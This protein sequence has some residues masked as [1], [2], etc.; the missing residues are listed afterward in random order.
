V[1]RYIFPDEVQRVSPL[2]SL[3]HFERFLLVPPLR[4]AM[5]GT[6]WTEKIQKI[7]KKPKQNRESA[8]IY[9]AR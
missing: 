2:V 6:F 7:S 5:P 3:G 1:I 4:D 8:P 9:T